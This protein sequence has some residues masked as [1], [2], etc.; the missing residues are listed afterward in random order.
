MKSLIKWLIGLILAIQF[1][2]LM[3]FE[4]VLPSWLRQWTG[5]SFAGQALSIGLFT[6]GLAAGA[7]F[8]SLENW[9]KPL[10]TMR[11]LL[12]GNGLLIL[13]YPIVIQILQNKFP[14]WPAWSFIV[15]SVAWVLPTA[16]AGG[17]MYSL[18]VF[19]EPQRRAAGGYYAAGL[20]GAG[21]GIALTIFKFYGQIPF[22]T[23]LIFCGIALI[24]SGLLLFFIKSKSS[25]EPVNPPSS[26]AADTAMKG[27]FFLGFAG[28]LF[29]INA[30]RLAKLVQGASYLSFGSVLLGILLPAGVGSLLASRKNTSANDRFELQ[31]LFLLYSMLI[32]ISIPAFRTLYY[33]QSFAWHS[34]SRNETGFELWKTY[35]VLLPWLF[36]SA[37]SLMN[38]YL[39]TKL[40]FAS[41]HS[42]GKLYAA[43]TLG[44]LLGTLAGYYLLIPWIGPLQG[45][46]ATGLMILIGALVLNR[47]PEQKT[48]SIL[49]FNALLLIFSYLIQPT[50]QE[51]FSGVFRTGQPQNHAEIAAVYNGRHST[52][53]ISFDS[54]GL[55]SLLIDGK[56][57]AGIS[58]TDLP[59]TDEPFEILLGALPLSLKPDAQYIATVGLGSGLSASILS[60]CPNIKVNDIIEIEPAV[61]EAV[62]NFGERVSALWTD[63]RN[64]IHTA[65]ARGWFIGHRNAYDIIAS[66]PSNP[67]V[68]GNSNLFTKEFYQLIK[69]S[70][71]EDGIF[72]QWIQ[73][74]ETNEVI[75]A[76][77]LKSLGQ[78]FEDY[79]LYLADDGNLLVV[80]G[81]NTSTLTPTEEIFGRP[82]LA[83]HLTR[84]GI[85]SPV[86][87][88]I[89]K[90]IN[91]KWM[92]SWATEAATE[93]NNHGDLLPALEPQALHAM[94][95]GDDAYWMNDLKSLSAALME[96]E[97]PG[98]TTGMSFYSYRSTIASR[99]LKGKVLY[100]ILRGN[101]LDTGLMNA[102]TLSQEISRLNTGFQNPSSA[103]SSDYL[104]LLNNFFICLEEFIKNDEVQGLN[105]PFEPSSLA[106]QLCDFH[107][108]FIKNHTDK[109]PIYTKKI[110]TNCNLWP[111]PIVVYAELI[112]RIMNLDIETRCNSMDTNQPVIKILLKASRHQCTFN[113]QR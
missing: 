100:D 36:V 113:I 15:F 64:L 50:H 73:L 57:D 98:I 14:S 84:L 1:F 112:N 45:T 104:V 88:I 94:F 86:D 65:D 19:I 109:I 78:V 16:V 111:Q 56:P 101:R 3:V 26:P 97:R 46:F 21:L 63:H 24:I 102:P 7:W 17:A 35:Q 75:L 5:T 69:A 91:K 85:Y 66:E 25:Q 37:P 81:N 90:A 87:L 105:H 58:M 96:K 29:Q 4:M 40:I 52:V 99:A 11:L 72:A 67:W 48:K 49:I 95:L 39:F 41:N 108:A 61:I 8:A 43:E 31:K 79:T 10:K 30:L 53:A 68:M 27:A 106:G 70:L 103:N 51:L 60:Q 9:S 83:R 33:L 47:K 12:A 42:A 110:L 89:R 2:G 6:G 18:A 13:L 92:D 55:M 59:S 28:M 32:F 23:V 44:T 62:P 82:A 22:S 80:A 38:G 20:I 34:I 76:A 54:R 71:K 93:V 107:L 77:I 74:Y